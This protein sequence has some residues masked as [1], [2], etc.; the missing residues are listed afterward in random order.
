MSFLDTIKES[1]KNLKTLEIRTVVGNFKWDDAQ[2]KIVYKEE[3]VKL[4]MTQIDLL[5]GDITTSFSED[6][7]KPPYDEIRKFHTEREKEAHAI[8]EGN[9]KALKE[10]VEL[11][12]SLAA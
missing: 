8:I 2:K 10:L 6:F 9:L 3:E 11:I 12:R 7:L 5:E 1:V 4:I